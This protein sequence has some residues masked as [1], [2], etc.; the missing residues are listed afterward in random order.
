[1]GMKLITLG[2]T[3]TLAISTTA[4]SQTDYQKV[5]A[6]TKSSTEIVNGV[7][8]NLGTDVKSVEVSG[9]II[10]FKAR[11]YCGNPGGFF[12][13]ALGYNTD[14]MIEAKDGKFR[15]TFMDGHFADNPTFSIQDHKK[16]AT[17]MGITQTE[18]SSTYNDC[19][20]G[21]DRFTN[22]LTDKIQK[23]SDF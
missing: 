8:T 14:V 13:V 23:Y 9:D 5:V 3:A 21:F 20:A 11:T 12:S 4:Y 7:K 22:T 17:F 2:L 18:N 19:I 10:K 16:G 6:V 1:M 15:I